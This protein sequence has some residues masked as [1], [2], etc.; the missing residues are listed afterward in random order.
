M[1]LLMLLSCA[2]GIYKLY[3]Q[4]KAAVLA[5]PA[6]LG[7]SWAPELRLRISDPALDDMASAAIAAG[8]LALDEK[9]EADGP[10]GVKA[11]IA[12]KL[13]VTSLNLGAGKDCEACLSLKAALEGEA[14][15]KVGSLKGTVPFSA[16]LK[17]NLS[18]TLKQDGEAWKVTGKVTD[19]QKIKVSVG[20]IS[21]LDLGSVLD[22]WANDI[23]DHLKPLELGRF[24][25][26]ALPLRAMRFAVRGGA[27]TLEAVTDVAGGKAIEAD[28]SELK[29]GWEMAISTQT[30]LA[31]ARREAFKMGAIAYDVAV[32]PRELK[33][34]GDRFTLDLRLWKLA[35]RGWWRDYEVAGAFHITPKRIKITPSDAKEGEKSDGAGIADPIALLAEGK[36]LEAVED[37]LLQSMPGGDT[38][39]AGGLEFQVAAKEIN[40]R[41]NLLVVRGT[42]DASAAGDGGAD[43]DDG[44]KDNDDRKPQDRERRATHQR[45][46]G[47]QTQGR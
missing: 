35:S 37:G 30:A 24:G 28:A 41:A 13:E 1:W 2:N 31:M 18:F 26:E 14:K 38:V 19:I 22:R 11:E 3:E 44:K 6:P 17:G 16:D 7:S 34:K 29:S 15:W 46:P 33:V 42:L 23:T 39:S 43:A 40:G 9:F 20:K 21:E 45:G 27:L 12:P 4:E 47:R 8:L 10:L 32:D 36:I 25:G 5:E